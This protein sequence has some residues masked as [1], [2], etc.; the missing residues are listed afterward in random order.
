MRT[1]VNAFLA[2]VLLST[3]CV[4]AN[5]IPAMVSAIPETEALWKFLQDGVLPGNY[6]NEKMR[7]FSEQSCQAFLQSHGNTIIDEHMKR[8]ANDPHSAKEGVNVDD[9]A[10]SVA[11]KVI[12]RYA[13]H[14]HK[15]KTAPAVRDA[16][17]DSWQ[18][19][20]GANMLVDNPSA[21]AELMDRRLQRSV[22]SS[23]PGVGHRLAF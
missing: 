18:M 20:D 4:L 16:V 10:K 2:L 17:I 1:S 8:L 7:H 6:D 19:P 22:R 9:K 5:D 14:R 23:D 12:E 13:Q 21:K 3:V 11:A 15:S